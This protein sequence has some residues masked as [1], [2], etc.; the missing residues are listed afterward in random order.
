MMKR[1]RRNQLTSDTIVREAVRLIEEEGLAALSARRLAGRLGCEAMSLYHHV[2]S[3]DGLADRIIEHLLVSL[4]AEE[5]VTPSGAIADGARA[6][7]AMAL[8]HPNAF[9]LVATRRWRRPG[10]QARAMRF[11]ELF[12][13]GGAADPWGS[14]RVLGAYLNGAGLAL[15]ACRKDPDLSSKDCATIER[16]L[17]AGIDSILSDLA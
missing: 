17:N 6:Y 10:A 15:A 1:V 14:A 5:G 11:V 3:M 9:P 12:A 4:P 2:Q 8:N 16:Q 7:L 13:K